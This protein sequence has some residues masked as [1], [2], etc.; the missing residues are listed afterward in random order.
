MATN[1]KHEH[2][3]LGFHEIPSWG[4]AIGF[5]KGLNAYSCSP[6]PLV[7]VDLVNTF[8]IAP[9]RFKPRL[10]CAI[11]EPQRDIGRAA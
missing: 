7:A 8:V 5:G 10:A 3:A 1:P 6:G 9:S 2:F 11:V 4:D